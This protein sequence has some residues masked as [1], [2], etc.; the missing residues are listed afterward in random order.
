MVHDYRMVRH[1]CGHGERVPYNLPTRL[2]ETRVRIIRSTPCDWCRKST[3]EQRNLSD[4]CLPMAG[5]GAEAA[6]AERIRLRAIEQ[7]KALR[8]HATAGELDGFDELMRRV[9]RTGDPQ[10]WIEH[11]NDAITI[12][13]RDIEVF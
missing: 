1:W 6:E 5:M 3:E 7:V 12:L 13:A 4:G 11:R 9:R 10:W 2:F 8:G